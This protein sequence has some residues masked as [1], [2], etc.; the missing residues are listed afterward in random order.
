M[1]KILIIAEKPSVAND[2]KNVLAKQAS[3]N[4]SFKKE[5]DYFESEQY[6]ISS[7]IGHLVEQKLPTGENGK[8]LPWKFDVLP[9]IPED[10]ELQPVS[11]TKVRF[12]VLKKL[13][14]RKD[15]DLI[16]NACDAG[17][18][19]EL[20]FRYITKL[21]KIKKNIQRLWLRSMTQ[22][23]I[24]EAFNN[25]RSDEDMLPLANAAF[26]RSESDWLIG[27]NSTRAMTAYNSKYGGFNKTPVGRVQTPTLAILADREIKIRDFESKNYWEVH[28]QFNCQNGDYKAIWFDDK[29]T[30]DPK[31]EHSRENRI[32]DK[33]S[34]Q[35][36]NDVCKN[37][38]AQV[39][40]ESKPQNQIAP[41]LFDLTSLQ[42]DAASRFGF[43]A[44][45]TLQIAQS[46]YEKHKA[47]TYPR[48][49]SKHLPNDY[50]DNVK[51]TIANLSQTQSFSEL[52]IA[53]HAQK[54]VNNKWISLNK[55]YFDDSKVSD[56]F[57]II[58]TGQIPISIDEYELRL[59]RLICQRLVASFFPAA[60][61]LLTTRITEI[62]AGN[63]KHLFKTKGKVLTSAGWLEVYQK[64]SK[65]KD[66]TTLVQVN[67]NEQVK[68][69][70][71]EVVEKTTKPPARY[72]ESTLL[73]MMET[74]GKLIEDNEFKQAM[75][76]RG[77]GTP[78][79]R[80]SIIEGLIQDKY[81]ARNGK[82]FVVN[83]RGIKLIEQLTNM[84][85][86][87]LASPEMTGKWEYKLKQ[88]ENGEYSRDNFMQEIKDLTKEVVVTTKEYA[89]IALNKKYP[90]FDVSCPEC[91]SKPLSQ[92]EGM[93][94]CQNEGCN[95]KL[96]KV[97]ASRPLS[98]KESKEL[99]ENL[100]L[101]TSDGF[102]SRFRQP[103]AAALELVKDEEK[104]GIKLNFIFE[105]SDQEKA[106]A[107][108][109]KDPNNKLCSCSICNKGDIYVTET[110]YICNQRAEHGT[111]VCK[112]R[113]SRNMCK[114][115]IPQEQAKKFFVDGA[116]DVIEKF[117]SKKGRPFSARL[118]L[119][120]TGRLIMKWEFQKRTSTKTKETPEKKT[121][122]KASLKV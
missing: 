54:I 105:K 77:L 41:M 16:I 116:T 85:I 79:T 19:G 101:P 67:Q 50:L 72:N 21:A 55:R 110:A 100:K 40:E 119:N 8:S 69:K 84:K 74:A 12:N 49:D 103:F 112:G 17:R 28:A 29:F 43:S 53:N 4:N 73:S 51:N 65:S 32:W 22:S 61:W 68:N 42:R 108:S 33:E 46:L 35:K 58:P 115:D 118:V 111:S 20:I 75:S 98:E 25:L 57:A 93:F 70:E 3:K 31:N 113:L 26:C 102:L 45:R 95:F 120:P 27:I 7:A 88:M 82:D 14:K 83:A 81:V 5:K 117:I 80:A 87:I 44:K 56:H 106:E 76:E 23:A 24:K 15:V 91:K 38:N 6:I 99:L 1:Q 48:T 62:E 66:D 36:I 37:K 97:I 11:K 109:V 122:S 47:I 78:A 107:Q 114:Y 71:I 2:I 94:K 59:Y 92:D 10:F 39:N 13:M 34:A 90:P 60:K 104:G 121:K 52:N 89:K 63:D 30:K 96:P 18:E 86:N 9:V 64:D